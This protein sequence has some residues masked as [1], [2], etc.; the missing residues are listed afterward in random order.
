KEERPMEREVTASALRAEPR[1][2]DL[3]TH[4]DERIL[5]Q[6]LETRFLGFGGHVS[7]G[8]GEYHDH[9]QASDDQQDYV[10]AQWPKQFE[11]EEI[12]CDVARSQ[13]HAAFRVVDRLAPDWSAVVD[14]STMNSSTPR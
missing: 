12:L 11:I 7:R 3:V 5:Q 4:P 1:V 6:R 13:H 14:R 8:P 10:G 9:E 2:H